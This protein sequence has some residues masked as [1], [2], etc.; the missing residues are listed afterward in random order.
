MS[1]VAALTNSL[2][3]ISQK[4]MGIISKTL[5]VASLAAV[6]YDS[7]V[8]GKIKA[9]STDVDSTAD[10]YFNQYK[11]FKSSDKNSA[12]VNKLKRIWYDIQK[13]FSF[14]HPYYRTKGYCSGF[15]K[16]LLNELPVIGL[17]V[18]ALATKKIGKLAGVLLGINAIKVLF[19]DV[20]CI[21]KDKK[22]SK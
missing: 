22:K 14:Y 19:C 3:N 1:K 7:H 11:Q 5:G 15:G 4:P 17:S 16:T 8:N 21:G 13:N 9:L 2:K 10:R 18:I 6:V 20:F 12:T